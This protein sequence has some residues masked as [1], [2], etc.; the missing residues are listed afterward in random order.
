ME[1][2]KDSVVGLDEFDF[3]NLI[4]YFKDLIARI[5]SKYETL[6]YDLYDKIQ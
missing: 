2:Y 4:P 5:R 6:M 3:E 1:V